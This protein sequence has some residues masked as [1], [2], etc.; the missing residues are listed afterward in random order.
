MCEINELANKL[1]LLIAAAVNLH[2]DVLDIKLEFSTP[3]SNFGPGRGRG[4][5]AGVRV[6]RR[7]F[8]P[9]EVTSYSTG[10]NTGYG[11][12]NGALQGLI[13]QVE[14]SFQKEELKQI[15]P[16]IRARA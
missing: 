5:T 15:K 2:P 10:P 7:R 3:T 13:E 12:M 1:R 4:W 8:D 6:F 11:Y 16:L 14:K 9:Q